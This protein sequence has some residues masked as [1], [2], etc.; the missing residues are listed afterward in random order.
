MLIFPKKLL[1]ASGA[2]IDPGDERLTAH[3]LS[4]DH[5]SAVFPIACLPLQIDEAP[6]R[7]A[8]ID[9]VMHWREGHLKAMT[10]LPDSFRHIVAR[11][12]PKNLVDEFLDPAFSQEDIRR[13]VAA[14]FNELA[15][16]FHKGHSSARDRHLFDS[17]F[18]SNSVPALWEHTLPGWLT[19]ALEDNLIIVA[20]FTDQRN[21]DSGNTGRRGEAVG[22][23]FPIGII[24]YQERVKGSTKAKVIFE[25]AMHIAQAKSEYWQ[26]HAS[27]IDHAASGFKTRIFERD[28]SGRKL[29]QSD[30]AKRPRKHLKRHRDI[31]N[32]APF[33]QYSQHSWGAE[34]VVD[35][36]LI[37][38]QLL[39][40]AHNGAPR[41]QHQVDAILSKRFPEMYDHYKAFIADCIKMAEKNLPEGMD[42]NEKNPSWKAGP[43]PR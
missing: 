2:V 8:A 43:L 37:E 32:N 21:K 18:N 28:E 40:G 10:V 38:C 4:N 6:F 22:G 11:V 36:A 1:T 30:D 13:S 39:R 16:Q 42:A 20:T 19:G 12:L 17:I 25:E 29:D 5:L 15:Q 7:Q 31:D 27:A 3:T 26:T 41:T 35:M 24:K 33:H 14:H 34:L 9:K 23:D